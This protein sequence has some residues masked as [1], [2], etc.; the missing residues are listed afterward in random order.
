[1]G[2]WASSQPFLILGASSGLFLASIYL[3]L[4]VVVLLQFT[5]TFLRNLRLSF[6][7]ESASCCGTTYLISLLRWRTWELAPLKFK[8]WGLGF[9][10]RRF[11][12]QDVRALRLGFGV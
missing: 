1:M 8:V 4:L 12:V 3:S 2:F 10:I 11:V 6:S 7:N 5:E 9:M